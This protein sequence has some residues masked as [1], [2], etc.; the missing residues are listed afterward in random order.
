MLLLAFAL[1]LMIVGFCFGSSLGL[2]SGGRCRAET[3]SAIGNGGKV[4][5][6]CSQ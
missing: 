5:D 2:M 6:G 1:N 4:F 3:E